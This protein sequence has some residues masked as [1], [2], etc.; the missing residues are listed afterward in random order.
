MWKL[1]FNI[2]Y[3]PP[4]LNSDGWV[5]DG[6]K[7]LETLGFQAVYTNKD[8]RTI[9]YERFNTY[10]TAYTTS[11]AAALAAT[12]LAIRE[13]ANQAKHRKPTK[14]GDENTAVSK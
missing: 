1:K 13:K 12:Y 4:N 3:A 7:S 14:G 9:T 8:G 2:T 5:L 6:T 10:L 11:A